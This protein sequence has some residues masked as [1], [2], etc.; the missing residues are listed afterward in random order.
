MADVDDVNE[1]VGVVQLF[2]RR[3]ERGHERGRQLVHEAHRVGEEHRRAAAEGDPSRR[4][5]ERRERLVGDEHVRIRERVHERGFPG[6][7]VAHER[8][9]EQP[10]AR[11]RAARP[12][13]LLRHLAEA[14]AQLL[15][16]LADDLAVALELR[17]AG[18]A[19]A[20]ATAEA[21]ELLALAGEARQPVL[22]LREL[23]LDATLPRARVAR[24]DVEDHRRPIDDPHAAELLER[25]L[26]RRLELVVAHHELGAEARDLA[27]DLLRLALADPAVRIRRAP[28]LQHPPDR[29]RV[30][31]R[32]ERRELL[33]RVL[34]VEAR[35]RKL[36]PH[37]VRALGWRRGLDRH[38]TASRS[39]GS[40]S[41]TVG[42]NQ[43]ICPSRRNHV[44]CRREYARTS[45]VVRAIAVSRSISPRRCATQCTYPWAL[46]LGSAGSMPRATSALASSRTPSATM[47][48]TRAAIASASQARGGRSPMRRAGTLG[49]RRQRSE[50]RPATLTT[51]R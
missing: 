1:E 2:E 11:P 45:R 24:E 42:S 14:L 41:S 27:G 35:A 37:E 18:A 33:E 5:I 38:A 34:A 47:R 39:A 30:G 4:G 13:A 6:V 48:R 51:S 32:D 10:F 17:L 25:T 21:R 20:D 28:L 12:L 46:M 50:I 44:I 49:P 40:G 16:A 7:R 8:R 19:R 29:D 23:Y 26:L 43:R 31:R 22:E 3:A 9:E 15:D 36:E